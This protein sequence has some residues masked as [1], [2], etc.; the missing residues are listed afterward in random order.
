MKTKEENHELAK[1]LA[2][3]MTEKELLAF[4]QS[5]GYDTYVKIATYSSQ[6]TAPDFNANDLYQNTI[7]RKI[8]TPKA[9]PIYPKKWLQIAALFVVLLGLSFFIKS[10][11]TTT[12]LA[13]NGKQTHFSLPDHSQIV[14]NSGSSIDYKQWNWDNNRNLNLDGEAYF[15][16]AHGKK[17]EVR[18]KL[19]SVTVLGT[20]FNV[21]ARNNRF[22]VT[23]YEGRVKVEYHNQTVIITK[24][25]SVTFDADYFERKAITSQKPEWTAHQ[26]VFSNEKIQN[27]I[28]ELERN[29]NCNIVLNT[30]ENNQLCTGTVP[31]NDIK[32]ALAIITSTYHLKISKFETNKIILEDL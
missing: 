9:L 2:G 11:V 29:Y 22:D 13:E 20:Q 19:G 24:G 25:T 7:S 16:V 30:K 32:T 3:E 5:P 27:I 23:C 12:E 26:I 8:S 15:K 14:L 1:W 10:S 18:T 17:F 6:L 28:E 4:Q 31:S 21:K